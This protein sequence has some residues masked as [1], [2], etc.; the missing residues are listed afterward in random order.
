MEPNYSRC[1]VA[2]IAL[3]L[4]TFTATLLACTTSPAPPRPDAGTD[5]AVDARHLVGADY[6]VT[7]D[8]AVV[9]PP[10]A[11]TAFGQPS[12]PN[13]P[14]AGTTVL[15]DTTGVLSWAAP[16]SGGIT[17]LT[18]DVTASGSG[19]VPATVTQMQDGAVVVSTAG[20][21]TG[22]F[23][24]PTGYC[25]GRSSNSINWTALGLGS[26]AC[27]AS[28]IAS[29]KYALASNGTNTLL[30]TPAFGETIVQSGGTG[31][32]QVASFS[33]GSN[34]EIGATDDFG[35]GTGVLSI[36]KATTN[37]TCSTFAHG[38]GIYADSATGVLFVCNEGSAT[39]VPVSSPVTWA[40]D[41]VGSTNSSQTVSGAQNDT[42]TF[43]NTGKITCDSTA[44]SCAWTQASTTN[45]TAS[46][47]VWAPQVSTNANGT[48]GAAQ[49]LLGAATGSGAETQFQI[50]H[51][52]DSQ[53][54]IAAGTFA[55]INDR[56]TIWVL[57]GSTAPTETNATI[58]SD[59]NT[60][61]YLNA[62][63]NSAFVGAILGL[64]Q[65]VWSA[66]NSGFAFFTNFFS[67]G[68]GVNVIE[69]PNATTVPTSNSPGAGILYETGGAL[70]H[71]GSSGAVTTMAGTG[72]SGT[73]NSQTQTLVQSWGTA[74]TSSAA[75]T[76]IETVPTAT[77]S[78]GSL[79]IK[80]VSRAI[81]AGCGATGDTAIATYYLGYKN[82]GGT[83][84]LSVTGLTLVGAVQT[85]NALVTSTMTA[86]A[87]GANILLNVVNVATC[88]VDSQ[89]TVTQI[90][91]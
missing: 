48:S 42:I 70:A 52:S 17:A 65:A 90:Q 87:S 11:N 84:S 27:V 31:G 61:T 38:S 25:I 63:S 81:S 45:T 76:L 56:G 57:N 91:N 53:P 64:G 83:A 30:N 36:N 41:L 5:A 15:T 12:L 73:I 28:S 58:Y 7:L 2:K 3:A 35:G 54:R 14:G 71:R 32:G 33:F 6:P 62:G 43:S 60:F 8:G 72:S 49:V 74:E 67:L 20:T 77:A 51:G 16:S 21:M 40:G 69:I 13:A 68:G 19:S 22:F 18:Q 4:A 10:N 78:G 59:G 47:S 44:S 89:V 86:T 29:D 24:A 79:D 66:N 37:P 34:V 80:L 1:S 82:V 88:T 46:A 26:S 85:T 55:G 39:P 9:G 23:S 75:A 50:F